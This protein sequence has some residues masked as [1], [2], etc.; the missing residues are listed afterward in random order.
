MPQCQ[1]GQ[2]ARQA[3]T[4]RPPRACVQGRRGAWLHLAGRYQGG[5]CAR[6]RVHAQAPGGCAPQAQGQQDSQGVYRQDEGANDCLCR[7]PRAGEGPHCARTL[8]RGPGDDEDFCGEGRHPGGGL[9]GQLA[10]DCHDECRVW[11]VAVGPGL[12]HHLPHSGSKAHVLRQAVQRQ[13]VREAAI[14]ECNQVC[15]QGPN[16]VHRGGRQGHLLARQRSLGV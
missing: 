1:G 10:R 12:Q 11:V 14:P 7:H 9:R 6:E 8:G 3:Q 5:H 2:E 16:P 15:S 4:R 13:E